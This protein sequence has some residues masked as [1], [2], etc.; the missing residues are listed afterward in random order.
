MFWKKK[1]NEEN[2]QDE[3]KFEGFARTYN[4]ELLF[5]DKPKMPGEEL[6]SVLGNC[7]GDVDILTKSEHL[8]A[9]VFKDYLVE[10]KDGKAPAQCLIMKSDKQLDLQCYETALQQS[11]DWKEAKKAIDKCKYSIVISDF[12]SSALNYKTRVNIF[13]NVLFSFLKIQPC[14]AMHWVTSQQIVNPNKYIQNFGD[15]EN[16]NP[17][18]GILNVR[19][20][21]ISNGGD[22][23]TLMDT[24]GLSAIGLPDLQC[25]FRGLD[26]NEIA[27]ILYTYG[28]YIYENGDVIGDGHTVQG[29][30][31]DQKW[32][33]RHEVSL[34]K[35]TREVLD[36]NPGNPFAAGNR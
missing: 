2:K 11:W 32:K 5:E 28:R 4:V 27:R 33:C 12:L 21:N 30:T 36:I 26:C 25:H 3:F 24:I 23:D 17:I 16:G 19:L 9:L 34:V 1:R 15:E 8:T 18:F 20:F 10:Y 22:G 35:P 7:C 14:L 29:I 6:L 31:E 13:K